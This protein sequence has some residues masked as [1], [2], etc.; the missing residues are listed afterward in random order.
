MSDIVVTPSVQIDSA[1]STATHCPYC[2]LQ[3]GIQL[4]GSREQIK[5]VG[6]KH[7]PVNKGSLCIKGWNASATLT[8]SERL[9]S[10]LIRSSNGEL[11]PA[12]WDDALAFVAQ[13]FHV[14]QQQHGKDAVGMFGGGSLTNEK[15]YLLGKF[16]RV[17][18]ETSNVDYNGRFCM[19]SAATASQMAFGLDRGLPFPIEDIAYT[20]MVLLVG[21]N[22]AETMPPLLHYFGEQ[23]RNGG[24]LILVDP[25]ASLTSNQATL[26]LKLTPGTDAVLANGILHIL[27]RDGLINH[28]Y[29]D[30]RTEDFSRVKAVAATYWP[31]RVERITGIPEALIVRV[32]HMLGRARSAMILTARGTEQQSQGVNNVLAYI[33]IALALGL[34]GRPLSGYGCITGQGNGQGGREHG[35][36]ADQLPGYRKITDPGARQHIANVWGIPEQAIP[37][38][39]KSAYEMLDT[40]GKDGGI[41]ALMVMGSN[42]VV[43]S[44]NAS[45]IQ[46][47]LKALDLLV[48][49]DF[50]LSETAQMADVV[51]P[52]AQWAEEEGTMTN[53]EGR[54]LKRERV[55][56]PPLGVRTDYDLL[57]SLAA[58]MGKG[59]FFTYADTQQIFDELR[60]ASAGGIADYSGITYEKIE[61]NQGVFWPCVAED[62]AGTPRLFLDRFPTPSGRARFHA[63]QHRQP[64]EAPDTAYPLYLTTGRILAQYQ[65]GTQTRRVPRLNEV[66]SEP[67][68]ELHPSTA[69]RFMIAPGE[70]VRLT[71]RRGSAV[72]TAKVTPSIREDTIFVPFHWGGEQSINR[73]TSPA[74]DPISRMPEFKLCAVRIER[75]EVTMEA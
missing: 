49:A 13:R 65:S 66:A 42:V 16:A 24:Q 25:R 72:F 75:C 68:V 15:A 17:A 37:L 45:H 20:D 56:E 48:V 27:I 40:A 8:H 60:R 36:K 14:I 35:Q 44:P 73:L 58:C 71:T 33:N 63:V 64:F 11:E 18:L 67:F 1:E 4:S 26:H 51:F 32:A 30:Q 53:L 34:V 62:H 41:R 31:E 22:I 3:C 70:S 52:S 10:P 43:S 19:S 9:L 38:A 29:I 47:R 5:L 39:G 57:C 7:F 50:F 28:Q 55:L 23:H 54:V 46:E 69:H 6:N 61:A 59:Q 12:S 2:A 74:L 21:S